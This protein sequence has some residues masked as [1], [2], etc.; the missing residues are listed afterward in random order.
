[1]GPVRVLV[2]T[3]E[4]PPIGGGGGRVAREIARRLSKQNFEF[5]IITAHWGNLPRFEREN[6]IYLYRVRSARRYPDRCSILEM[7]IYLISSAIFCIHAIS[8]IRPHLVH[9]HFAVPSGPL[10]FLL[11][12][13]HDIPYLIT[14]HGG[15]VPGFLPEETNHIF[16]ALYPITIPIWKKADC[17]IAVSESLKNLA[18]HAYPGIPVLVIPNGVR[19]PSVSFQERPEKE[20]IRILFVGRLSKQKNP[21][22]FIEAVNNLLRIDVN[23][24]NKIEVL[25]IGDGNLR[26]VVEQYREKFGLSDI[27]KITGWM[28]DGKVDEI[29]WHSDILVNTSCIEGFSLAVLQAMA[30]GLAVVATDV[31]GNREV[32]RHGST[33][34][35]TSPGSATD[36]A[37]AIYNLIIDKNLRNELG[38]NA[39]YW[40]KK[41]EWDSICAQYAA[42][43][44]K[45]LYKYG[46]CVE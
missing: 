3:Y 8:S 10:G 15:D 21:I 17:I 7:G 22:L 5:H 19:I 11:K 36:L 38:N 13:F 31:P 32:I 46:R 24:K 26:R 27:I 2:L 41:Y 30:L 35:L 4:Y 43:Y 6:G 25:M 12:K 44:K 28:E 16:R 14:L 37:N 29:M 34:W 42:I 33:G 40:A 9:V 20:K 39:F 23:L 1:M 18:E 45:I